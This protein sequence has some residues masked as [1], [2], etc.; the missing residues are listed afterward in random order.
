MKNT[1]S[2]ET[3][4]SYIDRFRANRD[5]IEVPEFKGSLSF[6]ET[7][8]VEAFKALVAQPG[9]V[10]VRIYYGMKEDLKICAVIVGVNADDNDMVG[11]LRGAET[12]IIIEDSELCPPLC[13]PNPAF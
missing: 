2:Y 3:A 1:I 4:K 7:F 10:G 6:S 9:C 13:S 8:H 12:D 11:V 5:S